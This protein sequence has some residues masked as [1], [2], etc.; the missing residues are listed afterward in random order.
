MKTQPDITVEMIHITKYFF[1]IIFRSPSLFNKQMNPASHAIVPIK[2]KN[3]E[4]TATDIA[5]KKI[6]LVIFSLFR[7]NTVKTMH[8]VTINHIIELKIKYPVL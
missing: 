6:E 4:K 2:F 1:L 5:D 8:K 7:R 3:V